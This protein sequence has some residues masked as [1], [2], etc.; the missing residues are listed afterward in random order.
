MATR[1]PRLLLLVLPLL[2]RLWLLVLPL[3][4][5]LLPLLPKSRKPQQGQ[6][7]WGRPDFEIQAIQSMCHNQLYVSGV[8][9]WEW[10]GVWGGRC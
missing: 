3:F 6:L 5:F 2:L 7:K 1:L 10:V 8:G 4:Q 9:G